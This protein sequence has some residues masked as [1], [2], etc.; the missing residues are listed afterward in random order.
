MQKYITQLIDDIRRAHGKTGQ[1]QS[2]FNLD[3]S[4]PDDFQCESEDVFPF[5]DFCGLSLEQFPPGQMLTEEQKEALCSAF[6]EMM[7]SY[8]LELVLP[9]E[10]PTSVQY[11]LLSE[12]LDKKVPKV[13]DSL[14]CVELC[15]LDP[16]SCAF[17]SYCDCKNLFQE[18]PIEDQL[19]DT[20]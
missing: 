2:E 3:H 1:H 15:Q 13:E 9:E 12:M 11:P 6:E 7:Y 20:I 4:L 14:H 16:N 19:E 5:K 17:G 8:N 10:L 18:D